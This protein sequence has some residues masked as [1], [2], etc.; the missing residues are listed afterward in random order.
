MGIGKKGQ[1]ALDF[2]RQAAIESALADVRKVIP[3]AR[4]CEKAA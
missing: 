4:L 1:I 2:I 3:N